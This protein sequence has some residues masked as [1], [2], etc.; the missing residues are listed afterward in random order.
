MR[1]DTSFSKN[2]PFQAQNVVVVF[3]KNAEVSSR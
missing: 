3:D 2:L 1:T